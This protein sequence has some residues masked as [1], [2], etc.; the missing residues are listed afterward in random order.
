M[1]FRLWLLLIANVLCLPLVVCADKLTIREDDGTEVTIEA[2]WIGE[3]KGVIV[4]ERA[5]G[6]IELVPQP[7]IINREPADDPEP[8]SCETIVERLKEEFGAE[9]FRAQISAPYVVGLILSEPLPKNCENRATNCLKKGATFMKN[10]EKAFLE[11]AKELK[12]PVEE[13]TKYPLTLLIFETDD[14]FTKFT[15]KETGGRGLSAGAIL[16]YYSPLTNRLVIRMS[17]CHS[18]STPLHEAIHQQCFN[19]GFIQRLAPVPA[20]FVE[21]I[22]TGFEGNSDKING[23]RPLQVNKSYIR[24]AIRART[25]DWDDVVADDAAFRGDVLAGEAYGNAWSIH[26]FLVTKYRKQYIEYLKVLSQKKPLESDDATARVEDFERVFGNTI[27][28]LQSEFPA[29]IENAAKKQNIPL[30]EPVPVGRMVSQ[31]NLAEVEL[32]AA[33]AGSRADVESEG[34]MR[35]LSQI[36]PMSFHITLETSGGTYAEWYLRKVDPQK[37]IQLEK[38]MARKRMKNAPANQPAETFR[39]RVRSTVPDSATDRAWSRGQLPTPI[40][41]G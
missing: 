30:V 41:S 8:V 29:W 15:T 36:R 4:L 21:G 33:K 40:F 34:R 11:F 14:D 6:R 28:K 19:R 32:T 5:D 13:K 16:G 25:V 37:V 20:W 10:V 7:Q 22:A 27:G 24:A 35:N 38:Q 39:I 18:M 1:R 26:W 9:L 31:S 2:R 3:R 17:E 23:K 12:F